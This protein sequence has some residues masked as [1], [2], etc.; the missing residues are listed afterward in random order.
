MANISLNVNPT[1]EEKYD[2]ALEQQRQNLGS[3][4][5]SLVAMKYP[6]CEKTGHRQAQCWSRKR[7]QNIAQLKRAVKLLSLNYHFIFAAF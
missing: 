7:D 1:Y 5:H 6:K 4:I 3:E 2:K